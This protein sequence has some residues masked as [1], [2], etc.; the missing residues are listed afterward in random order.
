[1]NPR[2]AIYSSFSPP[3][4]PP[5]SCGIFF[6]TASFGYHTYST[7]VIRRGH[8][9]SRQKEA[10][11]KKKIEEEKH[12]SPGCIATVNCTPRCRGDVAI[13]YHTIPRYDASELL[14]AATLRLLYPTENLSPS[15]VYR[16]GCCGPWVRGGGRQQRQLGK[17]AS[18]C[19]PTG[20]VIQRNT[21]L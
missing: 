8:V 6:L 21:V 7:A 17:S 2:E 1:M 14:A 9:T 16:R 12:H 20:T 18:L 10:S 4:L 13:P 5:S 11:F 19:C 15:T 3:S